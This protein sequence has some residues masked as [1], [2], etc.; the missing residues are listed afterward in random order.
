M[1]NLENAPKIYVG[2]Y[3][4]YNDGSLFGKW[5]DL[6]NYTDTKE[7]YKNCY[8][9]HRNEFLPELMFQDWENI[10]DFLIS[11]YSL[12]EDT[13]KYFETIDEM[14]EERA[15][16]FEIYC[17]SI[18]S[19]PLNGNDLDETRQEFEDAYRGYFSGSMKGP[20]LEF[21][22][23]YIEESGMLA[24]APKLLKRYF[25]Y[26]SFAKDLFLDGYSQYEGHVFRD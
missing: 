3:G 19:W 20:E 17:S 5:F 25:D 2:T 13:F 1:K 24:D 6:S 12:H 21:I 4:Q 16:A 9:Y 22:Y 15:K 23:Q 10:P 8:E 11:E 7:F 14:G 18:V 26:K